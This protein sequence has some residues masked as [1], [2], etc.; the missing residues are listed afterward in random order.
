MLYT[1]DRC[2]KEITGNPVRICMEVVDRENDDYMY[3]ARYPDIAE[4]DF[5]RDCGDFIA[6]RI[7]HFCK[8]G[9]PA[10]IN[11]DFESAV[12]EMVATSQTNPP[13]R[14]RTGRRGDWIPGR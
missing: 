14:R 3:E 8:K 11:E 6:G 12:E 4:L 7:R 13:P 9:A 5:C 10:V 1:C 2:R